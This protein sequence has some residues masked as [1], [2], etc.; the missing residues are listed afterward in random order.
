MARRIC[1]WTGVG[2]CLLICA[3]WG[4][5]FTFERKFDGGHYGITLFDGFLSLYRIPPELAPARAWANAPLVDLATWYPRIQLHAVMSW[6]ELPLW[7][8]L[9]A[10]VL[11]T[12]WLW[13]PSRSRKKGC[14]ECGYSLTGNVSGVCPECGTAIEKLTRS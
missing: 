10:S 6:I 1:K 8:V 4:C 9:S 13:R 2:M 7:L 14:V 3:A 11:A 5:G 12:T